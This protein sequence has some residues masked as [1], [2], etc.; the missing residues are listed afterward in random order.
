MVC[1][2]F[3]AASTSAYAQ[4]TTVTG[5]IVDE[6]NVPLIGV[7]VLIKGTSTG[8]VSDLDGAYRIEVPDASSILVFSYTGYSE[9]EEVLNGRTL[10]DV[11]LQE[12][13]GLNEVV[14][15][16]YGTQRKATLTGSVVQVKGDDIIASKPSSST[17]LAL[18]GEM[19]GVVIT[20]GTARPG[21]E[22]L[23]IKIRGDISVNNVSPLI[24]LDGLVIPESQLSTINQNDIETISVLKDASAAIYGTR[25]SGGVILITTK[26]GQ[27]GKT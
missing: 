14:V 11:V 5:T 3:I 7:N 2:L 15:V 13:V 23:D 9:A 8:T 22:G 1:L 12:G 21:N 6:E 4:L 10:I 20:R 16:G 26:K 27:I 24:L 19:P 25:A 17:A 18:Q